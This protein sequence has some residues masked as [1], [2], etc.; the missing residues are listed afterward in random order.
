M[1]EVT[2]ERAAAKADRRRHA[3]HRIIADVEFPFTADCR[4]R[5]IGPM[6]NVML[7]VGVVLSV[8]EVASARARAPGP[9]FQIDLRPSGRHIEC[10]RSPA[11]LR[12][13]DYSKAVSPG[14]CD[15]GGEVLTVSARAATEHRS[16]L[17]A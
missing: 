13:L 12:C 6:R 3:S 17:P 8:A 2:A 7:T 10:S 14:R 9:G 1:D 15:V 5:K 11:A 4:R 16:R